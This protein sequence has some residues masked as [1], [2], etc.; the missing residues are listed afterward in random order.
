ISEECLLRP[1]PV[2]GAYIEIGITEVLVGE[3]AEVTQRDTVG[4]TQEIAVYGVIADPGSDKFVFKVVRPLK[5][6]GKGEFPP[7][8]SV[9]VVVKYQYAPQLVEVEIGSV[10]SGPV[11]EIPGFVFGVIAGSRQG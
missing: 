7:V 10:C 5:I 8:R 6:K 4:K 3:Q 1:E 11:T 9:T 2:F